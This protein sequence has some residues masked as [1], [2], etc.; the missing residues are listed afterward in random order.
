MHY[1]SEHHLY[2]CVPFA[3]TSDALLWN[4]I[5]TVQETVPLHLK[6]QEVQGTKFA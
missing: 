4:L 5:D 1:P 6:Q 2:H 3:F